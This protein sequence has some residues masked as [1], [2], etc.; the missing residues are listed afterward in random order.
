MATDPAGL[1][2]A[3]I[4]EQSQ[5]A[6]AT[7]DRGRWREAINGGLYHWRLASFPIHYFWIVDAQVALF[8]EQLAEILEKCL[9][10]I[11]MPWCVCAG[12]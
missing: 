10:K 6:R 7:V 3:G 11:W 5:P 9:V 2:V 8:R 4:V 1:K 12:I